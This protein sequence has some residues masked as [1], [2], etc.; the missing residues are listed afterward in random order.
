MN[1]IHK[2]AEFSPI[3]ASDVVTDEATSSS[4][5]D[6][7]VC[8]HKEA[9]CSPIVASDVVTDEAT[10]SSPDDPD[11][12]TICSENL[13]V[14]DTTYPLL[15]GTKTCKFNMCQSCTSHL[16]S[17]SNQGPQE[18]SDGNL[19][20]TKAQCPSCRAAFVPGLKDILVLRDG[21]VQERLLKFKD[22]EL[23]AKELRKKY[24][25]SDNLVAELSGARERYLSAKMKR[26]G[27]EDG[28]NGH[29]DIDNVECQRETE[30]ALDTKA[31]RDLMK[32]KI[33]HVDGM[34]FMGLEHC[35]SEAERAYVVQIMTSG[36]TIKLVQAAQLFASIIQMNAMKRDK[37]VQVQATHSDEISISSNTS[38]GTT[39]VSPR[40]AQQDTPRR[41][42]GTP[43]GAN[44]QKRPSQPFKHK[45]SEN[46]PGLYTYSSTPLPIRNHGNSIFEQDAKQRERWSKMYPLP[47]R[48]P[49]STT[50]KLDF[51]PY[52]TK[53]CPIQFLDD[54][55]SLSFLKYNQ[56]YSKMSYEDRCKL[57]RDAYS[58][59]SVSLWGYLVKRDCSKF[60][61]PENVLLGLEHGV[62][63][64]QAPD[65][66][67]PW[68][69]VVVSR[70]ERNFER[71]T[72][73][74]AG[75]VLTHVDGEPLDGNV[76]KLRFL[77]MRKK[78]EETIG[79][80]TPTIEFIVNAEISVAEALRLRSFM[81]RNQ[82]D[83]QFRFQLL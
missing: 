25:V 61:G 71:S 83:K 52:D 39:Q 4:S 41:Q 73:I 81:A 10:S 57:I 49:R 64:R 24:N 17:A 66:K 54:E 3:V 67:V 13:A 77:L 12:C 7:D 8:I 42:A 19:Y 76:E 78:K 36:C 27:L 20:S 72:G 6:P 53:K 23:N 32:K 40:G 56:R 18:A 82:T 15:C 28:S 30:E 79:G 14:E 29:S 75:D 80:H 62:E 55:D 2:E 34:V 48:M 47:Y 68:R 35:M 51:D 38:V 74:R 26:A 43:T 63:D 9:E 21:E 65:T 31:E 46:A 16:L 22:A 50:V 44:S 45:R 70:V 60:D 1:V 59:L 69:R 11:V 37:Q 58:T 33:E 5:D